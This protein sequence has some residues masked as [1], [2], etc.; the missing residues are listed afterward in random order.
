MVSMPRSARLAA[1]ASAWLNGSGSLDDVLTR[2]CGDDEPHDVVDV[3]GTDGTVSLVAALPALRD[4]GV[5]S[6]R[7]VLPAPGDPTGLGGPAD[8]NAD[9]VDAGE[10]VLAVGA[11]DTAY[12]LVPD[13]QAFGPPGD[14]GHFVTWRCRE[15][16][17]PPAGPSLSEAEQELS[18]NLREAGSALA[19]LDVAAWR[20][21][22]A[23]LLEEVRSSRVAEP[24]PRGF[25][26]R[27][28]LV[29][30]RSIRLMAVADFALTDDGGAVSA[31]AAESR[32]ALLTPLER[33]ARHALVAACNALEE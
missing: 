25:P 27:A 21:E 8:L 15:A 3:P 2:V 5:S 33:A 18:S 10:T 30:A 24:L 14:Q 7:V 26:A 28:Q 11:G 19:K 17:R 6:F 31:S 1:W 13:I 16:I 12:A 20:P 23:T 9:A 32:R 4:A 29:A 22:V